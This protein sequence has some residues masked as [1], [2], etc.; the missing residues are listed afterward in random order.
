MKPY[1]ILECKNLLEIQKETQNFLYK[2]YKEILNAKSLWHK[3]DTKQ[4][5]EEC[6]ELTSWCSSMKLLIREISFTVIVKPINVP[7]HV[8]ELPVTAKINVPILNTEHTKNQWYSIPK[9]DYAKHKI[10]NEFGKY[11]YDFKDYDLKK[12]ELLGEVELTKPIV[13]NSQLPHNV[14]CLPNANFPRVVLSALFYNEPI[15]FLQ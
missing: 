6:K 12:A 8:D 14:I 11:Y 1:K 7:I 9:Q 5:L 4:Y 13:F 15:S 10:T 2:H 3:V